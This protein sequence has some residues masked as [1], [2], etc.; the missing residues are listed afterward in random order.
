MPA[1]KPIS[2]TVQGEHADY[3]QI[4]PNKRSFLGITGYTLSFLVVQ[5][6]RLLRFGLGR[7][8]SYFF[9]N[10]LFRKTE[11]ENTDLTLNTKYPDEKL[12]ADDDMV[13]VD[14]LPEK[15]FIKRA[16]TNWFHKIKSIITNSP[17][18]P[19]T[20]DIARQESI[21]NERIYQLLGQVNTLINGNT[22]PGQI[23]V[24]KKYNPNQIHFRGLHHLSPELRELFFNNLN[25]TYNNEF[26]ENEKQYKFYVLKTRSGA[27]LDA[28]EVRGKGVASQPIEERKFI[29]SCC[30]RSNNYTPWLKQHRYYADELHATVVAF[31]YSGTG[32]SKGLI[33]SQRGMRED[34]IAQVERLIALGAKPENIALMGESLGG[35]IATFAAAEMHKQ[36]YKVKLFNS[37]S[38]RSSSSIILH[39][40]LPD[41]QANKLNPLN[42]GRYL[43]AGLAAI[44]IVPLLHL[45]QWDLSVDKAFKSIPVEDR[46]YLVVRSKKDSSGHRYRDD[47]T[48]PHEHASIYSLV[49]GEQQ[50]LQA[51]KEA[52]K[53]LNAKEEAWLNDRR[54]LHKFHVDITKRADAPTVNGH[55]VQIRYLVNT[56][57]TDNTPLEDGREYTLRFFHRMWDKKQQ[58][59]NP[60]PQCLVTR[61]T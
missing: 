15:N 17:F 30:P 56:K 16:L 36:G 1:K 6:L 10:P 50:R 45:A 7:L 40:I 44:T 31:N 58:P 20:Q 27:E 9:L 47:G 19:S 39:Q 21:N 12:S 5:P 24:D 49:K 29:V 23:T 34:T 42:W 33:S 3:Y 22:L 48:V 41:K 52:G 26:Q 53:V 13:I 38:L 8:F 51:K 60:E 59:L 11:H 37:R 35:N 55:P 18:I 43:L 28:V 4:A 57:Q 32:Q 46:D 14:I 61:Q 2:M 54:G 25:Q